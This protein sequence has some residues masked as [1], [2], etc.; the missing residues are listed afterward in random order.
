M[1]KCSEEI[2][3]VENLREIDLLDDYWTINQE[4]RNSYLRLSGVRE[5]LDAFLHIGESR[6]VTKLN[7][8][9]LDGFVENINKL[10][11]R[12]FK[13]QQNYV[14]YKK[15]ILAFDEIAFDEIEDIKE[16]EKLPQSELEHLFIAIKLFISLTEELDKLCFTVLSKVYELL[17]QRNNLLSNIKEDTNMYY[18]C[19]CESNR[20]RAIFDAHVDEDKI[21]NFRIKK[22]N[23]RD[24]TRLVNNFGDGK[25]LKLKKVDYNYRIE[26]LKKRILSEYNEFYIISS[27]ITSISNKERIENTNNL[28]FRISKLSPILSMLALISILPVISDIYVRY[29]LKGIFI[30]FIVLFIT[31]VFVFN[32]I[33]KDT[34][35]NIQHL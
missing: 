8:K 14:G 20:A 31:G 26:L 32:W 5:L 2:E 6:E 9:I 10:E 27:M 25:R 29:G 19:K 23:N 17:I 24:Y 7:N 34:S 16:K 28:L 1:K 21:I 13:L 4:M 18:L 33:K 3:L 30:L 15:E 12:F 22:I 35:N 11:V